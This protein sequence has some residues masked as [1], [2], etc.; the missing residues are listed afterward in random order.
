MRTVK[1]ANRFKRDYRREKSGQLGKSLD[2]LL[3][4]AVNLL[5]ANAPLP[6]RCFDHQLSGE[7]KDHRDCHL[8]PDLI[9]IYRL[10]DDATLE[11]VRLGSHSE[12]G[13]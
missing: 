10:P 1:Y 12:L 9:L 7:W 4:E 6:R 13:F 8:R 2:A 5:A 11:L 3:M